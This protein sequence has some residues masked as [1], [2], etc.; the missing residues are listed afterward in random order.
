MVTARLTAVLS[1][2][3]TVRLTLPTGPGRAPATTELCQAS[4]IDAGSTIGSGTVSTREDADEDDEALTV[5]LGTLP[6]SVR[7]GSPDTTT[8]T[9]RDGDGTPPNHVRPSTPG[10]TCTRA[11]VGAMRPLRGSAW[12]RGCSDGEGFGPGRRPVD[13]VMERGAGQGSFTGAADARR[14]RAGALPTRRGVS[15]SGWRLRRAWRLGAVTV[16]DPDGDE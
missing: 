1:S 8:V 2:A 12:W 6:S 16:T 9:I 4:P 14:Q 7:T 5:T 10:P 11:G 15:R 13:V 3:V